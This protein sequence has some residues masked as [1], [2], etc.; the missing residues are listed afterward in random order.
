MRH[1]PHP[2]LF[3]WTPPPPQFPDPSSMHRRND[4]DTSIAAAERVAKSGRKALQDRIEQLLAIPM[5]DGE[6][7]KLPEFKHYGPSTVRKRRSE[8]FK[9]DRVID[10]GA[11]RN[12]MKVWRRVSA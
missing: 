6:L 8:L 7:E 1:A 5:T 12:G 3:D 11:R 2:E 9:A 4:A 10:T